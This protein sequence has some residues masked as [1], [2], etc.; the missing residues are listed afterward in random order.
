SI[1]GRSANFRIDRFH[2]HLPN[3]TGA[4]DETRPESLTTAGGG[5]TTP[6]PPTGGGST[7]GGGGT[8][9]GGA[10]SPSGPERPNDSDGCGGRIASRGTAW[11]WMALA[12]L[13]LLAGV[14]SK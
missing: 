13:L 3:V 4:T 8:T 11:P 6:P 14:L 5:T 2:L 12:L 1:S 7:G 9:G 10:A